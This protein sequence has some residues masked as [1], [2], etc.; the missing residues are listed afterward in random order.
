MHDGKTIK[1]K[2]QK[3]EPGLNVTLE[4]GE[5]GKQGSKWGQKDTGRKAGAFKIKGEK[6]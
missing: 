1:V 3:R 5:G 2:Y 4:V 6:M